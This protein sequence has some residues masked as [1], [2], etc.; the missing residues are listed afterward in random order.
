MRKLNRL[1]KDFIKCIIFGSIISL[2]VVLV[3]GVISLLISKFNLNQSI[4]NVRSALLIIGPLGMI[5]GALLILKKK[6]EKELT[7][8]D[9][10]KEKYHVF[11]YKIVL[12]LISAIIILYGAAIDWLIINF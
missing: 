6:N 2:A 11:S 4:E 1:L 5:V 7:F 8:I 9:D 12:I 3:V 10:W